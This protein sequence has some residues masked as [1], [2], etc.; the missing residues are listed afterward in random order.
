VQQDR[1]GRILVFQRG[2][3]GVIQGEGADSGLGDHGSGA[4]PPHVK[5][6]FADA[7][8]WIHGAQAGGG[9]LR[10][11]SALDAYTA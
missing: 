6:D 9:L 2:K 8:A 10:P 7:G 4:F 3:V 11:V 5:A 1:G